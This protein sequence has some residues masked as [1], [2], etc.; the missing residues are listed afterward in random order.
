MIKFTSS[1]QDGRTLVGLGLSAGNI[2]RLKEGKPIHVHF[3]ELNLPYKID[4][5]IMYGETEQELT[6]ELRPFINS[7]T[8]ISRETKK[9]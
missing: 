5:M 2:Q 9:Q 6:K 3:E 1:G 4:L 7:R 8:V